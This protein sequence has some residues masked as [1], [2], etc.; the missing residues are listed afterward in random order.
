MNHVT[1]WMLVVSIVLS[2]SLACQSAWGDDVAQ[3]EP[4]PPNVQRPAGADHLEPVRRDVTD[5]KGELDDSRQKSQEKLS[6]TR[7]RKLSEL[8]E[9]L[10][11]A[12][13]RHRARKMEKAAFLGV[14]T[15]PVPAALREQ[16]KLPRGFGLVVDAVE[17]DSPA[18]QAGIQQYDILQKLN[19]QL[20]VNS[21]QLAVLVRSMKEGQTVTITL[22]RAGES[23]TVTVTL[24]EKEMPALGDASGSIDLMPLEELA[25]SEL[26]QIGQINWSAADG[27]DLIR[28]YTTRGKEVSSVYQDSEMTLTL[29][30]DGQEKH[31]VATDASGEK[32]FE[33]PIATEEQRSRLPQAVAEKL[34]KFE[35]RIEALD[36]DGKRTRVKVIVP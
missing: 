25:L 21:Q 7:E 34:Q 10:L 8:R 29:T 19:D 33:G 12:R 13:G 9:R 28:F 23:Q 36:V 11:D 27:K 24:R 20:L 30:E 3:P 22:L 17:K 31:L 2:G 14:T 5:A 1:R 15:S 26:P 35:S 16:M 6:E 18:E 32:L 4:N